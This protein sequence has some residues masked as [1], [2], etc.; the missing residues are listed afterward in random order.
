[1]SNSL[2]PKNNCVR[3]MV[4]PELSLNYTYIFGKYK[5][6]T[7][8]ST[9]SVDGDDAFLYIKYITK[10]GSFTLDRELTDMLILFEK[11]IE[12]ENDEFYNSEIDLPF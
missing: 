8:K 7:I 12:R 5:G 9:I 4:T 2:L 11:K 3:R 1:M 6:H 10:D